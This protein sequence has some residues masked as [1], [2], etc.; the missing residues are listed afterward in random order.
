MMGRA[1]KR[2]ARAGLGLE[3]GPGL[4]P[5]FKAGIRA[6]PGGLDGLTT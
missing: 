1:L 5:S 6:G 3:L 2:W 4:S